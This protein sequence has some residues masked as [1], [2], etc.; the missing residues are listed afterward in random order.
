M[1]PLVMSHDGKLLG[2][3]YSK[4]FTVFLICAFLSLQFTSTT[5]A[6]EL[7][8]SGE[9]SEASGPE[10]TGM[11]SFSGGG[12]V[13]SS[14]SGS[15]FPY[16]EGPVSS[17]AMPSAMFSFHPDLFT[18]RA[19]A[20][21]PILVP[22]GR[23]SMQPDTS[24]TYNSAGRNSWVGWGWSLDAGCIQRN[25]KRGV[26]RYD[27]SDTFVFSGGAVGE[28]VEV[29]TA[30]YRAKIES[31]FSRFRHI[32][33]SWEVTD[34][35]GTRLLFGS[36]AATR[37]DNDK[38]TFKWCLDKVI[39]VDG[40]YMTFSYTKDNGQIYLSQ[41]QY[42][43]NENT[44][45][46]PR[47]SID[48]ILEARTDTPSNFISG[49]NIV[50][51][52]RL[53]EI[54]IKVNG[55]RV[56]RY[57]LGY[58]YS[59]DSRRSLLDT[60]TQYGP[61]GLSLP[62]IEFEY[63]DNNG[64]GYSFDGPGSGRWF[65]M[66]LDCYFVGDFNGDGLT[67]LL[68]YDK[69]QTSW[70]VGLSDGT[71][72]NAPGSGYW[73]REEFGG[74]ENT[75]YYRV[76]DFN[77]DGMT[78][79]LYW[80]NDSG[81]GYFHVR[82]STGEAFEV[83]Q[84]DV[85]LDEPLAH[86]AFDTYDFNGDGLTDI[87]GYGDD[88][89][90]HIRTACYLGISTGTSFRGSGSGYVIPADELWRLSAWSWGFADFNGDGMTDI[91]GQNP[92]DN[93]WY[94]GISTGTSF[95]GHGSGLWSNNNHGTFRRCGDFN[96]D[97]LYDMLFHS[98]YY[99]VIRL[100][101]GLSFNGHGS[102]DW[103]GA[104]HTTNQKIADLPPPENLF[105]FRGFTWT[106][107][108]NGDGITDVTG[109]VVRSI[110]DGDQEQ[111]R[112]R[113]IGLSDGMCL[114]APGS[115]AWIRGPDNYSRAVP[116]DYN[117]D[118]MTD[119]AYYNYNGY[120]DVKINTCKHV[121]LL[122]NI[123]NGVGGATTIAY[124]P[125]T[126]YEN[127][128]LPFVVQ[129]IRSVI[130]DDGID[131]TAPYTSTY[132][133]GDGLYNTK[134]REFRGF[135]YAKMTDPGG[136]YTETWFHQDNIKKGRPYRQKVW[137]NTGRVY[138]TTENEWRCDKSENDNP[139]YFPY[140]Y[141]KDAFSYGVN[142]E[143]GNFRQSRARYEYD[144]YGNVTR[145]YQDGDIDTTSDDFYTV[146]EYA[147]NGTDWIVSKPYRAQVF[148]SSGTK[149][150]ERM[151]YYDGQDLGQAPIKGK[152]TKGESWL[153]GDEANNPVTQYQYDA[154]GNLHIVTDPRG[155]QTE[156]VYDADFHSFPARVK[157]TCDNID[158][159]Q[160]FTH[161]PGTGQ[162]LTATDANGQTI[163]T[164][165]DNFGRTRRII[166]PSVA[167]QSLIV[168]YQYDL[169]GIPDS[170][171]PNRIIETT[172]ATTGGV[173]E[174][175]T[176]YTFFDGI[177]RIL[178]SK[179]DAENTSKQ[180]VANCTY[181]YRGQ[182]EIQYLPYL[183]NRSADYIPLDASKPKATYQYDTPGRLIR[184]VNSDSSVTRAEYYDESWN[185]EAIDAN[186]HKVRTIMDA[187]GRVVEVDEF[188]SAGE[189]FATTYE[190][191]TLGNLIKVTDSKS[192]PNITNMGYDSLGRKIAM[193][194]PDMG[195]WQYE[196]DANGNLIKQTD[197][198]GGVIEFE[199]DSLNRLKKKYCPGGSSGT[200][201]Y[202][203]DSYKN[204]STV[205]S[206]G[207]LAYVEYDSGKT[208]VYYDDIGRGIRDVKEIGGFS[209]TTRRSYDAL[210]RVSAV[211]Y[212]DGEAVAY[213]YNKQGG[214][215]RIEGSS[216]YVQ[217]IDY[218]ATSQITHIEY[219]NG[220]NTD[221]E[222]DPN[223]LRLDKLQ[224]ENPTGSTLQDLAY[225]F[226]KVGNIT[227][228]D[229]SLYSPTSQNL[230]TH[231]QT[232]TYDALNRLSSADSSSYGH[233]P[234]EYDSIGNITRKG[235]LFFNYGEG[236]AGPHALTSSTDGSITCSYDGNGNMARKNDKIYEYDLENHLRKVKRTQSGERTFVKQLSYGWNFFSIP[237]I[238]ANANVNNVL[239]SI[240]GKYDQVSSYDPAEGKFKHYINN[241][242]YNDFTDIE[243][244]KGYQIFITDPGGATLTVTG[245]LPTGNESAALGRNWNI[246][247]CPSTSDIS[248]EEALN[249]LRRNTDYDRI[250]GYDGTSFVENPPTLE[251]GQAYYIRMLHAA[252]WEIPQPAEA[253]AEFV[254]N[255]AGARIKKVIASSQTIYVDSS[256]E[257]TDGII[258]KH[259]FCG[260]N[261]VASRS[262]NG[263]L[264]YFHSDHLGSSSVITDNSGGVAQT[265]EYL[266]YG[267]THVN[268]GTDS[269]SYKFTGKELDDST[270]LY[271]Y[272]ARY[273]DP[274]IA[275]FTQADT[276]VQA[277]YD[278]Q[279]LNRYAY[280][281][282][283]PLRY[284]DPT[285]HSFWDKVKKIFKK[286]GRF[287]KKNWEYITTAVAIVTSF[288]TLG[289]S[290][291]ITIGM[292]SGSVWG[293]VSAHISGG[294]IGSGMLFGT[295][296]GGIT[297]A[298]AGG[299]TAGA[300]AKTSMF[301]QG[302]FSLLDKAII[303][304]TEFAIA[305][306]GIGAVHGY[307]G[308]VGS[309]R[310]IL[311]STALG[312]GYGFASGAVVGAA[313]HLLNVPW[314]HGANF[315]DPAASSAFMPYVTT[316]AEAAL[317][318]V[319]ADGPLPI[320]DILAIGVLIVGF[321]AGVVHQARS[322]DPLWKAPGNPGWKG[323]DWSFTEG[324][325][326]VKPPDRGKNKWI[327]AAAK[328]A[329]LISNMFSKK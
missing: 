194:D 304:G 91:L 138:A 214:I 265:L 169:T 137:D 106:S 282:N 271:Y 198:K 49:S 90:T 184:V 149:Q 236:T 247:A 256:Y 299:W 89:N 239:S 24:L 124:E 228:I 22:P 322:Q 70:Y 174:I 172:R 146:T 223:T 10:S 8:S 316:S 65:E 53:E 142:G 155:N 71:S 315:A 314:L 140:L 200:A 163:T 60:V 159:I 273:Y 267:Q 96:G 144:R 31:S 290:S 210:D 179:T 112:P 292:F 157:N 48:F 246:I 305:G 240:N 308:G 182:K 164:E 29:G 211:T 262:S 241:A 107:E 213:S 6:S 68:G 143:G 38:G 221:Y 289:A 248:A 129:T 46:A 93:N 183:S 3:I 103:V 176:S 7:R 133:F 309:F 220:T 209:Y 104:D 277:P 32:G 222:Y 102:G 84:N 14:D 64:G 156:T 66:N 135:G 105:M 127:T 152:L 232:F 235:S 17:S 244:G 26:P 234:Y 5:P 69:S 206:I 224:T 201:T 15:H 123:S 154:Y 212:P 231:N 291:P 78:D 118:G 261:R 192:P 117:G 134:E 283:N 268:Q 39:D 250:V 258:S 297:G 263:N 318:L 313:G 25:T 62:P 158:H 167:G 145:V 249:N 58:S 94:A 141:K 160:G 266:P 204:G 257:V 100:S 4:I 195:Q 219:G 61:D 298:A 279:S 285:G 286:I 126:R 73:L 264:I 243:Y 306:A 188:L 51:A 42:A 226:D 130:V 12:A 16:L 37:L 67:D 83:L 59:P 136:D 317:V 216:V 320:G 202:Y 13:T 41:I 276:I 92:S 326:N 199:Y 185:V 36:T 311:R 242:D 171:S 170:S 193:D 296:I 189:I 260:P 253:V 300:T 79:L 34:K 95:D 274:E 20:A 72:F 207:R 74:G 153:K 28:L 287:F 319:A 181:N 229:A 109:L 88:L 150:S 86:G 97:G 1:K 254:Y 255:D 50:T 284:T 227:E 151:L 115:G 56:R 165:Y 218:S 87:L 128:M 323:W 33:D 45:H 238:P 101:T 177:G 237:V 85:W 203:Y 295:I 321:T 310:D 2:N 99:V 40:N 324:Q 120:W 80:D 114:D 180:I 312:F 9:V 168:E 76:A 21:V 293:G 35:S 132:E 191:D 63:S 186:D 77:G 119:L 307:A 302:G 294:D 196:Y 270:G 148:D 81:L 187:Y 251:S 161:D 303:T 23:G 19:A 269:T 281:R 215:E 139:P 121:D 75:S 43:G 147:Y 11:L 217:N 108:F 113:Y 230:Y 205:N 54:D 245:Q 55:S 278:P 125:S 288:M 27:N 259:I 233:I 131:E 30:E 52:Q 225:T 173:E 166:N 325:K 328:L 18:G 44:G 175:F 190:Y 47:R 272:G 178:Q 280:C 98:W 111:G 275:R 208:A 327:F 122:T 82:R 301:A 116:R 329:E 252:T 57:V 197:A 110:L 162:M